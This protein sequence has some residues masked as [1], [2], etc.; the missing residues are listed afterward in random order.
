MNV[1]D[2]RVIRKTVMGFLERSSVVDEAI[3]LSPL[4]RASSCYAAPM[5]M[6]LQSGRLSVHVKQ[7]VEIAVGFKMIAGNFGREKT[8][9][10]FKPQ[11][12]VGEGF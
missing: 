11:R 3:F 9:V 6:G 12:D 5:G 2:K 1:L 10:I 7:A 4:G 8:N